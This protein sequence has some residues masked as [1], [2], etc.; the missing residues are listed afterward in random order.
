MAI[1]ILFVI[2]GVVAAAATVV[3]KRAP[4]GENAPRWASNVRTGASWVQ[5]VTLLA[6]IFGGI[7]A[8]AAS[9]GFAFAAEPKAWGSNATAEGIAL[10]TTAVIGGLMSAIAVV[11]ISDDDE[12]DGLIK[13][14]VGKILTPFG[15][16]CVIGA[17]S[18]GAALAVIFW[19]IFGLVLCIGGIV[20]HVVA[21][22]SDEKISRPI[23]VLFELSW[24]WLP[25][26]LMSAS[27]IEWQNVIETLRV[28]MTF[29]PF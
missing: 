8:F 15:V 6:L 19:F 1:W 14:G 23:M 21:L 20:L 25:L 2:V 27:G 22:E 7:Y 26:A 16:A 4:Y 12:K 13:I 24:A 5:M 28:L 9:V 11:S 10:W 18:L 17:F 3:E 29:N